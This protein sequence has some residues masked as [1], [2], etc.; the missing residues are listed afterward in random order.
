MLGGC[1]LLRPDRGALRPVESGYLTDYGLLE[2]SGDPDRAQFV[3][4]NP[5]V[6]LRAYDAL[7]FD[8]VT[9]WV[10]HADAVDAVESV[11]L[12]RIADDAYAAVRHRLASEV[13]LTDRA[14]PKT[15]RLYIGLT[16]VSDPEASHDVFSTDA[17]PTYSD[18]AAGSLD[19]ATARFVNEA[20]IE[21]EVADSE[22]GQV[23]LAAIDPQNPFLW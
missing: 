7:V 12:Q 5:D 4:K 19:P 10:A 8:K 3:Y 21:I 23:L 6:D 20:V 1:S 11:D 14:G 15:M 2:P 13:T 16:H 9:I 22:T 17:D 18:D